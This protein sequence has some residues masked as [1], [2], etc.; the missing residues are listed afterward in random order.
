MDALTAGVALLIGQLCIA[1]VMVGAHLAARPER[2]T[3]DWALAAVVVLAGVVMIIASRRVPVLQPIGSSFLVFGAALQL[4]GL[5][6]FF[7]LRRGALGWVIAACACLLFFLLRAANAAIHL[8]L[9]AFASANLVLFA[10]SLHV[11]KQGSRARWTFA[12]VLTAGAALLLMS[13]NVTR[14][15][16]AITRDPDLLVTSTPMGIATMYLVP[17]GGAFVYV[18]GLLLLYFERLVAEKH[19][20]ATRDELT[21]LLNRRAIESAGKREVEVALRNR[22]ALTVAFVDI[23]FLK[24]VNDTFGHKAGDL[25]IADVATLLG[26]ACRTVDLVGRHGGDEFCMVFPCTDSDGAALVGERLLSAM[27][28]YAFR[29]EHP[30]TLSIGFASLPPD[31]DQSWASLINRADVALYEA[32]A[33]GRN[34]YCIALRTGNVEKATE[35]GATA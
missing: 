35:A 26:E 7:K 28:Q 6:A 3:R 8:H 27:R 11:L 4:A 9:I 32:K 13:N 23:D 21:G 12:S 18:T 34:R 25:L 5:Q 31:G 14:I 22:H 20:L 16:V 24:Q 15:V 17:L 29:G 10:M 19:A 1:L 33:Q 2:A 30:A